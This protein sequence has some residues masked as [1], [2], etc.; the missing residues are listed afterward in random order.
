M[1]QSLLQFKV[2]PIHIV[3][4]ED[5]YLMMTT[6]ITLMCCVCVYMREK[7]RERF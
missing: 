6:M 5:P 4:E 7:E 1:F 2:L 3:E